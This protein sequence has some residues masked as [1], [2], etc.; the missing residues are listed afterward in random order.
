ME[1]VQITKDF[2]HI[3]NAHSLRQLVLKFE[4]VLPS[5]YGARAQNAFHRKVKVTHQ[6]HRQYH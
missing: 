4:D 5:R 2:L 3:K 6:C 1:F